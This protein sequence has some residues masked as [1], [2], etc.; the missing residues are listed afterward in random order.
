MAAEAATGQLAVSEEECRDVV[1]SMMDGMLWHRLVNERLAWPPVGRTA[2][3]RTLP[4]LAYPPGL[5]AASTSSSSR[6]PWPRPTRRLDRVQVHAGALPATDGRNWRTM[7]A[8]A[9][10]ATGKQG[11]GRAEHGRCRARSRGRAAAQGA[12][13]LRWAFSRFVLGT[14][15]VREPDL[16]WWLSRPTAFIGAALHPAHHAGPRE[17]L[18]QSRPGRQSRLGGQR[19]TP[20]SSGAEN[21]AAR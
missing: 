2:R 1:W 17:A 3:G 9:R 20:G 18:G 13:P 8:S 10:S 7:V 21:A 5:S 11:H 16:R 14:R 19:L 15:I 4:R 6:P 12:G